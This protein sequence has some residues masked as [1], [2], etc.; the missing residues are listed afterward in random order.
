M[1][2]AQDAGIGSPPGE[3][4]GTA[5]EMKDTMGG[6]VSGAK[7]LLVEGA[8]SRAVGAIDEGK[9]T[10][11][12]SLGTVAEALREA[13]HKFQDGEAGSLGTYAESAA[14]QVDKVA[15]YIRERDFQGLTR[16]AETF[17]RRHPEVFLGGAFLA[18]IFA[19]RFLKSSGQRSTSGD[20]GAA[21][22]QGYQ[23]GYGQEPFNPPHIAP[24]GGQ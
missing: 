21:E 15:R 4:A 24:I 12:E 16:D 18:G 23:A 11:A 9:A 19:A 5:R 14:A 2:N 3:S 13:A 20:G 17:A 8:K 10:A 22:G 1:Q 6:L 7:E